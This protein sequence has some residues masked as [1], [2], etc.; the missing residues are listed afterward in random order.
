MN[1]FKQWKS[2]ITQLKTYYEEASK[3]LG[4]ERFRNYFLGNYLEALNLGAN[5]PVVAINEVYAYVKTSVANLYIKDPYIAI[6]AK[7]R[8]E[9]AGARTKELAI[10]YEWRQNDLK[11][12]VKRNIG[13]AKLIGFSWIKVGYEA[14]IQTQS[15]QAVPQVP[16]QTQD[17]VQDTPSQVPQETNEYIAQEG[18]WTTW[19]P[20]NKDNGV[21]YDPDSI[22]PPYDSRYLVH[23]YKKP[24]AY[25]KDKYGKDIRGGYIKNKSDVPR[26]D[27]TQTEYNF[28]Y[29]ISDK[30]SGYKLVMCDGCEE[31]LE[32]IPPIKDGCIGPYEMEGFPFVMLYFNPI[33]CVEGK[34]N[35]PMSDIAAIEPQILE[36]I[37]LRSMQLNHIK[38]FGR[39]LLAKKGSLSQEEMD[40]FLLG[41]DG[42][43]IE[44]ETQSNLGDVIQPI[45]YAAI[46]SDMYAVENRVD[47]DRDKI[48]G[49]S[50]MEQG[51]TTQSKS[52]TLGEL[53]LMQSASDARSEEQVDMIETFC[54]QIAKKQLQLMKQFFDIPKYARITGE[55]PKAYLEEL[56][57]QGK[58]D[59]VSIEYTKDDIQGEEDVEIVP[60][61]TVPMNKENRMRAIL[62]AARVGQAFGL[63]PTS[64]ATMRMGQTYF[65]NLGIQSVEDAYEYDLFK[66]TQPQPPDPEKELK[67]AN[68]KADI[69]KKHTD[70]DLK[71]E[72]IN[73]VNLSNVSK[74]LDNSDKLSGKDKNEV[75]M[76][77]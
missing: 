28:V 59:G 66:L 39:Q 32:E 16:E 1:D 24:T 65:S 9:T 55:V 13:D 42:A 71:K 27:E 63:T 19:I 40:K 61:S 69:L 20:Q 58:Y 7:K 35:F 5:C 30:E 67:I 68:S 38:R 29:E 64:S 18:L 4:W 2:R 54:Q 51:G 33:I 41:I 15:P 57:K 43:V 47:M 74:A 46:Q 45:N 10:N 62:E 48:S 25:L 49:Q 8:G 22:D 36:K 70:N 6:N 21:Y 73:S 56:Q 3:K 14:E 11:R 31:W 44:A 75:P 17:T 12:Q 34:Y 50:A 60:G 76:R 23:Y 37:K 53:K 72:R 52:R 26:V 77:K